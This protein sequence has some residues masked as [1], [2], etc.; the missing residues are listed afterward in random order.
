MRRN[1]LLTLLFDPRFP[2]LFVLGSIVLALLG[3]AVY[4]LIVAFLGDS[5]PTYVGLIVVAG[6]IFVLLSRWFRELLAAVARRRPPA[7]RLPDE[8]RSDPQPAL[9]MLVGLGPRERG[10]EWPVIEWHLQGGVLRHCWLVVSPEGRA[11]ADDLQFQLFE[12]NVRAEVIEIDGAN[13]AASAH[14][15]VVRSVGEALGRAYTAEQVVV[16]ITGG[17]K[18]M[19]AGAA[20]ACLEQGA[21]IEYLV[22]VRKPTGEH[23]PQARPQPMRIS[24]SRAQ[25]EAP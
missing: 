12:R 24:L 25:Q 20:L 14:A 4:D 16:D 6:L 3:N 2:L 9:V 18:P 17:T 22:S 19:S 11:H 7:V 1:D 23:D 15:A 13:Q 5:P 21:V 10:P 8:E